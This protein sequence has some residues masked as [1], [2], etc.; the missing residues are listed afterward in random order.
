MKNRLLLLVTTALAVALSSPS[1][2]A[3]DAVRADTE[4][5]A[6]LEGTK[7]MQAAVTYSE[8][9]LHRVVKARLEGLHSSAASLVLDGLEIPLRMD[10]ATGTAFLLLDSETDR[11]VPHLQAKDPVH[12]TGGGRIVMRGHL[13][14][15]S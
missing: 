3:A 5:Q 15:T 12:V 13:R 11:G 7:P 6:R 10:A 2:R 4:L 14:P 9:G 1:S 8:R